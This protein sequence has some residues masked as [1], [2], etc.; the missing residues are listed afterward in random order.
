VAQRLQDDPHLQLS[1]LLR[2]DQQLGFAGSYQTFTR[3]VR[4]RRL[5]PHFE[6]CASAKVTALTEI[7]QRC[8]PKS[9]TP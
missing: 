4:S 5:R 3:Q 6:A 1:T 8:S 9:A 7:P 2:E